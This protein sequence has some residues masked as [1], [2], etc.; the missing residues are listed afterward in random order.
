MLATYIVIAV[1]CLAGLV[2]RTVY[3][4]LKRAGRLDPRSREVFAVVFVGMIALLASWPAL[5]WLDP[6]RIAVPGLLRLVGFTLVGVALLLAVGG[7]WQLRGLE[8]ID[9]LVTTGLYS[10]LR[11]PM[12]T[13]FIA[14]IAGWLLSSGAVASLPLAVLCVAS[15][16]S[17]R[18]HEERALVAQFGEAYGR[19]R[20]ATWL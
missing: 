3:E 13:G 16:L 4:A 1:L 8:N 20:Q 6:W 18:H 17:W 12:Y 5:G 7:V 11:H 9:H 2:D 10:R 15:I 14:W 19:Y